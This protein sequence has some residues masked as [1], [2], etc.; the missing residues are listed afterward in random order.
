V[1]ATSIGTIVERILRGAGKPL[2]YAEIKKLG[3]FEGDSKPVF[4]A[5]YRLVEKG[6]AKKLDRGLFVHV[7]CIPKES[8]TKEEEKPPLP[9]IQPPKQVIITTPVE[10]SSKSNGQKPLTKEEI[11]AQIAEINKKIADRSLE[12]KTNAAT[13]IALL[14]GGVA[15]VYREVRKKLFKNKNI[16]LKYHF[17]WKAQ[18]IPKDVTLIIIVVDMINHNL[19]NIVVEAAKRAGVPFVRTSRKWAVMSQAIEQ[20]L[21]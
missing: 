18:D 12:P 15:D 20:Q 3:A 1:V 21:P 8:T 17:E 5:L 19:E 16:D 9:D 7:D 14:V 6:L 13:T 10:C 11:A 2:Q 4:N